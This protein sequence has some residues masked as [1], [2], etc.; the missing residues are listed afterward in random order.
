[1]KT[2]TIVSQL[3]IICMLTSCS[4]S[5]ESKILEEENNR[6]KNEISMIEK[7]N[8]NSDL[9]DESLNTT[10][11]KIFSINTN[12]NE[13]SE[14]CYHDPCSVS[15][16]I[17]T[18]IITNEENQV[19]LKAEVIGGS[20]PWD[21]DDI[22]WNESPHEVLIVCSKTNPSLIIDGQTEVLPLNEDGISGYLI[23]SAEMYFNYCHSTKLP[24]DEAI[25]KFSYNVQN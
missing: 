4:K 8:I 14:T 3:I 22:E 20:K 1:M 18:E 13:I 6:L 11:H 19:V 15:K 7:D 2:K 10:S 21:S 17:S 25:S 16:S 12:E 24:V 9:S 5:Q 23:S